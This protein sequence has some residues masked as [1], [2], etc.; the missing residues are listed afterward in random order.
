MK[1]TFLFC[2]LLCFCAVLNART[3]V[4][5]A[6]VSSYADSRNNLRMSADDATEFAKVMKKQTKDVVVVTSKYANH[7]NI[8]Q[9]YRAIANRAKDG[10]RIIFYFSG[11]GSPGAINSYDRAIKYDEL[12]SLA[13]NSK[14]T[15]K[16]FI[17]DA[18]HSGSVTDASTSYQ[19]QG[20]EGM[21][22]FMSSRA[23]EYSQEN[24][25][26]GTSTFTQ[27]IIKGLL[28]KS[29]ANSDRKITILELFQYVYSDVVNRGTQSEAHPQHP[30]LIAPKG[31]LDS[32]IARWK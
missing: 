19:M 16:V 30:V 18:C 28:G 8:L 1:K 11:H 31:C 2:M 7:D 14:A 3:Y 29:D 17:I 26:V 22:F 12:V 10:D 4:L 21:I 13:H 9:K 20:K 5:A 32:V 23:D 27:A 25:L 24:P 6:G 15:E